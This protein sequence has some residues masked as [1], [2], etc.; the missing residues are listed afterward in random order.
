M[1]SNKVEKS[2]NDQIAFE[3]YASYYYLSMASWAESKGL[4]GTAKFFYAHSME[5]RTHML[6]IFN[7]ISGAGGHA[8]SPAIKQPPSSFTSLKAV[9]EKVLQHEIAGT[10]SINHIVDMCLKEKDHG[11]ANFLQWFIAEQ[12]E[13][14]KLFRSVLDKINL[15]GTDGKAIFWID[16][17]IGAINIG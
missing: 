17:E 10:K 4:E 16:K 3:G 2:L 9:F 5:E 13:E 6:K 11:T 7:Y 14:E 12:H 1:L 8:I 15:M